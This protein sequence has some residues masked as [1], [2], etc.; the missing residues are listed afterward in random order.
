M[1]RMTTSQGARVD[2]G[3]S[4]VAAGPSGPALI[5]DIHLL[6]KLTH[7]NRGRTLEWMVHAKGLWLDANEVEK[8]A[9]ITREERAEVTRA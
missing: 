7:F 6:D 3:L 1:K 9:A 8:I 5:Q 2:N 4:S